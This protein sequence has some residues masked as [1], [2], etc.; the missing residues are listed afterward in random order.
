MELNTDQLAAF[1]RD[2][3]IIVD[4]FF[5][6]SELE[7]FQGALLSVIRSQLRKAGLDPEGFIGRE[8]G[9]A[10]ATLENNS[11][12]H[13]A[14]IY[15]I[16]A[17][18]PEFLRLVAKPA[19]THL[20]NQMLG[21][22]KQAPLYSMTCRCRVDPPQD[23]VVFAEWHQEI[24]YSVPES[25]FILVWAPLLRDVT[26]Q[27]GALQVCVGSHKHGI[28]KQSW[29]QPEGRH[30]QM[31]IDPE[32]ISSHEQRS[33]ELRLG[34]LL[35]FSPYLVHKSGPNISDEVRFTLIGAFHDV[36]NPRFNAPRLS[37]NYQKSPLEY[38]Q[39]VTG[40]L[41]APGPLEG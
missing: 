34:Q 7:T 26:T 41:L 36:D 40:D 1:Q 21:R 39:Q 23:T 24:F 5:A 16:L 22:A 20:A 11:H 9:A 12:R 17:N 15:N 33:L 29:E 32:F 10:M 28:V 25:R 35:F 37:Y 19:Y 6:F 27:N 38:Y 8:F 14:E 4:D 31:F 2:G 13:V 3:F 18:L 30:R